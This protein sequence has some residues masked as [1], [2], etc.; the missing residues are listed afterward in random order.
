MIS[1]LQIVVINNIFDDS[2]YSEFVKNAA[3][4]VAVIYG[5]YKTNSPA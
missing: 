5:N 3:M 1:A 4:V 2:S